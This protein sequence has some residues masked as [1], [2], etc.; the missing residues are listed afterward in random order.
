MQRLYL[1]ASPPEPL[2]ARDGGQPPTPPRPRSHRQRHRPLPRGVE[3]R[4]PRG[5]SPKRPPLR[6]RSPAK[7][8]VA[9]STRPRKNSSP[10]RTPRATPRRR[11]PRPGAPQLRRNPLPAGQAPQGSQGVQVVRGPRRAVLLPV[12]PVRRDLRPGHRIL[13]RRRIR[14][15]ILAS[16]PHCSDLGSDGVDQPGSREISRPGHQEHAFRAQGPAYVPVL[17]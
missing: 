4:S 3:P 1:G 11:C 8:R 2:A 15:R 16:R 14:A 9:P 13:H 10:L 12:R 6:K 5:Q 17:Q 7:P